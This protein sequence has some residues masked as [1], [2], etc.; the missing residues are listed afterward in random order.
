MVAVRTRCRSSLLSLALFVSAA[1]GAVAS[2]PPPADPECTVPTILTRYPV[3]DAIGAQWNS[4][5]QTLAYGRPRSAGHYAAYLNDATGARERRIAYSAWRDDRH[6]FPVAWHPSGRY[7]MVTVEE[8]QHGGRSVDAIPGYGAYSNYWLVTPDGRSAWQMTDLPRDRDHAITHAAF[9][10]DG[11]LFIWTE[12]IGAPRMS[13]NLLAG[14]YRF[15]VSKFVDGNPPRLADTHS[16]VP[17]NQPQGG[18]VESMAAD[19]RTIAFHSTLRSH[20][21][22][23]SRIYTMDIETG[24]MRELTHESFA[25][26]PRFTPSGKHIVYMT[27]AGAAVFP[28][29]LQGADWWIMDLEGGHKQRLTFM[30]E[31]NHPQSDNR[32]RLAG[33]LSFSADNSFYGDVLTKSFG[34]TGYIVQVQLRPECID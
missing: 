16:F 26:A 14:S 7:L 22:I 19:D 34:L 17:S 29:S 13:L 21:L 9:S 12:R 25:Q 15:N 1:S 2:G 28:F 32:F 30:N 11:S 27:G 6:Q 4:V 18:E 20:S 8:P 31:R 3:P 33:S 5:T 24:A 23:A 10:P